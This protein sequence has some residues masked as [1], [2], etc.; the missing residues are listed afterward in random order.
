MLLVL[1]C[2]FSCYIILMLYA[3]M[4]M[5]VTKLPYNAAKN[6][7]YDINKGIFLC[8]SFIWFIYFHISSFSLVCYFWGPFV[9]FFI[10]KF[11][12]FFN[13]EW[14]TNNISSKKDFITTRSTNLLVKEWN[15]KAFKGNLIC[16]AIAKLVSNF[17]KNNNSPSFL[18]DNFK[19]FSPFCVS[20]LFFKW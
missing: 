9:S 14:P 11:F 20:S 12:P 3:F 7:I 10:A 13:V 18:H 19:S 17:H 1:F 2:V 4:V 6:K 5:Q 8:F 15:Q 16:Y